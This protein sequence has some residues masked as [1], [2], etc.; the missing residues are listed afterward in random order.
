[1][2]EAKSMTPCTPAKKDEDIQKEK[3]HVHVH[4]RLRFWQVPVFVGNY[5]GSTIA[6]KQKQP[7]KEGCT[8]I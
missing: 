5:G 3:I 4:A 8:I 6:I 2:A 7:V 1:M